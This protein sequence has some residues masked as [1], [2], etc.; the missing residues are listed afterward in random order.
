MAHLPWRRFARWLRRGTLVWLCMGSPAEFFFCIPN[1]LPPPG[2]MWDFTLVQLWEGW[3]QECL[4]GSFFPGIQGRRQDCFIEMFRTLPR[5]RPSHL[6]SCIESAIVNVIYSFFSFVLC[7]VLFSLCQWFSG[8]FLST[9]PFP[10]HWI[11]YKCIICNI[12]FFSWLL[13]VRFVSLVLL[14]YIW[15][16]FWSIMLN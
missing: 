3:C 16:L 15:K 6:L 4:K 9:L 10:L 14:F 8:L 1:I 5:F 11:L 13:C 7:W 2:G 12:Y